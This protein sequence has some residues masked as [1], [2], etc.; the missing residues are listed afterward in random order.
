MKTTSLIRRAII[1][2]L[3]IQFCCALALV[4]TAI[5]H[6]WTARIRA[7]E[8]AVQGRSDSLIGAVQDAE[9]PGD[10][11]KVDPLEFKPQRGDVYAVYNPDGQSVGTSEGAP[12]ELVALS[13][14]GFHDAIVD[15]HRYRV[16]QQDAMR[17]IDREETAGV[18]IRRPVIVVYATRTDHVWHEVMET[19]RFYVLM[20]VFLLCVTAGVLIYLLRRVWEPLR[21]LASEASLISANSLAFEPPQSAL[22]IRELMPLADALSKMI[23]RLRMAFE[24]EHRFMNDAAHELKTAVAVVRSTIQLLTM[25]SRTPEEYQLGLNRALEDNMRVEELVARMLSLAHIS[26]RREQALSE[27]DLAHEAESALKNIASLAEYRGVRIVSSLAQSTK[28]RLSS[29]AVQ[30]LVSNL[31]MNSVQHSAR[32]AEVHVAVR[33][34]L[35]GDRPAVL[36]VQDFGSG[37]AAENLPHVFE[38]FFREDPSRSR[39]TGGVGLGL[40][41]CKNIVE[42]ADGVIELE[43]IRGQG[44]TVRAFFHA[45]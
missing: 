24:M 13:K 36:E 35:G 27:I 39:E 25:R 4:C 41:I 21:K 10:H 42:S 16:L 31:V 30:T 45:A 2:V 12:A 6:E 17:I 14:N 28:V 26:E 34:E 5:W 29:N 8:I 33:L 15:H 40:A 44:T 20:S 11:V 3:L 19:V 22:R 37:I 32:G 23:A 7:L 43:S 9:D 1:A 18:G 38:R